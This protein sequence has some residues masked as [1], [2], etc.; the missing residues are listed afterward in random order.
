[1]TIHVE[2]AVSV[3]DRINQLSEHVYALKQAYE[4]EREETRRLRAANDNRKKL[5]RGEVFRI[6]LLWNKGGWSQA[7]LADAF[8]VNP[9]TVS[10]IVRG[11]YHA[12]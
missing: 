2:A 11:I 10:R 4:A 7:A 8:D 12:G 9:A 5:T 3:S 6:R 1:M